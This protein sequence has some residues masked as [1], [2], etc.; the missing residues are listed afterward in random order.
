V[1][2]LLGLI[3][4]L[5]VAIGWFAPLA[6]DR[7]L[8]PIEENAERFAHRKCLVLVTL[9]GATILFR[10]AL[11]PVL[12]VPMPAVH[13]EFSYLLAADTFA[14]S[15][16]SNPPHPMWI[17][18]DTF[19]VL[20]HP[21]Y[22]SKYPPAPG[23]LM[24]VGELLGHP[25]LGVLLSMAM[26]TVTMTWMLQGWFSPPWALLGGLLVLLHLNLFQYWADSYYNGSVAAAGA[27]LTLGAYPRIL[28]SQKIHDAILM[29]I[30][31]VILACSRPFEGLVFCLP[32]AIALLLKLRSI[33]RNNLRVAAL[34]VVLP[35]GLVLA[36]GTT[37]LAYYN[38]MVTLN[39]FAFPYVV[40]HR[41]YFNYP[42]FAWQHASP[43]QHY[44][45]P[46][47]EFF[48]NDWQRKA[49]PLTWEGWRHRAAETA[50]IWWAVFLGPLWTIP[51]LTLPRVLR[52][53]RMRLPVFQFVLCAIGLL[54]VVWFQPHY[55][56][57]LTATLMVLLIPAMCDLRQVKMQTRPTGIFLTRLVVIA[58]I[59]SILLQAGHAALNP[60]VGWSTE[61]L[62]VIKTLQSLDGKHLVI[63]QYA[64][65]HNVH[66]EWVYN[67]ADIDR[68]RIVWA[69]QVPGFNP[70]PLLDYFKDRK[71][72]LLEPD[73]SPPVLRPYPVL[74][75]GVDL[76]PGPK[77]PNNPRDP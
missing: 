38:A 58:T 12:P 69:R 70:K 50:W 5:L 67:D 13:D 10:L 56:A 74:A 68:S 19:H 41:Q 14:H 77:P 72:W 30:G 23:A 73:A 42:I 39:P 32:V 21:T 48:F 31:V 33:C 8:S 54:S 60:V 36:A 28:K 52:E 43:P 44:A 4:V 46:Q 16:L 51:F 75:S 1:A 34:R 64:P 40:Y 66:H 49:Y 3:W 2:L 20:Q 53:E 57:P 7:W 11:L 61:R 25:W 59:A 18:F 45:N 63:V 17:F 9:G 55:A 71:V 22:A 24:A 62:K 35:L 6:C 47:F 65:G 27:A 37:F 29:G 15:R 76:G 26:M